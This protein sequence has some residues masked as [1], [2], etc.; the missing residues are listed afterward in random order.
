MSIHQRHVLG[1]SFLRQ[2]WEAS[3]IKAGRQ[4]RS[5]P[6]SA[7]CLSTVPEEEVSL[8]FDF[9]AQGKKKILIAKLELQSI[10]LSFSSTYW[11]AL[12]A[13]AGLELVILT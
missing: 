5:F 10:S 8:L 3:E 12:V 11:V 7:R 4:D 6:N 13:Q 2:P 1:D 9:L